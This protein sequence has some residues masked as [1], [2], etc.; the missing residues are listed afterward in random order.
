MLIFIL[1]EV[2]LSLL[3]GGQWEGWCLL[4]GAAALAGHP[5]PAELLVQKVRSDLFVSAA[6]K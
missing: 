4:M 5:V 1:F 2:A 6:C 3:A